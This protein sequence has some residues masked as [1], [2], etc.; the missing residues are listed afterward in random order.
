MSA[1]PSP[2]SACPALPR[3]IRTTETPAVRWLLM[4]L[5]LLFMALFLALPLAAVFA[6]AL[7]AG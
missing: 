7:E 6:Q 3:R 4:A 5:A 1:A 2:A